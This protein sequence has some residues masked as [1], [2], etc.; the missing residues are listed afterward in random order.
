[1]DKFCLPFEK[2]NIQSFPHFA[3]ADSVFLSNMDESYKEYLTERFID[4][5][6][7]P[8]AFVFALVSDDNWGINAGII[9][10]QKIELYKT[11]FAECEIDIIAILKKCLLSHLYIYGIRGK[12]QEKYLI[13]GYDDTR[14]AFKVWQFD[15]KTGLFFEWIEYDKLYESLL[16][17]EGKSLS[18]TLWKYNEDN[19]YKLN[20]QDLETGIRE[21]LQ[22]RKEKNRSCGLLVFK[23]LS[24]YCRQQSN[25]QQPLDERFLKGFV[26]HKM[27]MYKRLKYLEDKQ[28]ILPRYKEISK[29]VLSI[30]KSVERLSYVYNSNLNEHDVIM[31]ASLI[32]KTIQIEQRYLYSVWVELKCH[33]EKQNYIESSK[34][35]RASLS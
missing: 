20:L 3:F 23:E 32:E 22:G 24:A 11:A 9:K 1:M 25:N 15:I 29:E 18:I 12:E 34:L 31:I 28:I 10:H 4:F 13:N 26:E 35:Y 21:Y 6:F 14:S 7:D 33:I 16:G 8:Q 30:A 19:N 5:Y 17:V 27:F 2:S